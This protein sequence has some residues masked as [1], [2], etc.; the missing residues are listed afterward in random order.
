MIKKFLILLSLWS[1]QIVAD[2]TLVVLIPRE[3]IH[4]KIV[5]YAAKIDQEYQGKELTIVMIMKGAFIFVAD[6]MRELKV[7]AS[8]EYIQCCSYGSNTVRGDLSVYGLDKLDLKGKNVLLM[9]DII[10]T[11]H[12]MN[13]V[14]KEIELMG[15]ASIRT[16]VLVSK[17]ARREVEYDTDDYLF[18]VDNYFVT[19]Y[20]LDRDQ[21]NRGIPDICYY[22]ET[23]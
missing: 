17:T 22:K 7:P 18:H 9:D 6:F 14:V 11:G 1:S 21:L 23:E 16:C 13:T 19:G 5:E 4:Q 15:T 20:G 12:T 2:D 3:E 10:D 8:V